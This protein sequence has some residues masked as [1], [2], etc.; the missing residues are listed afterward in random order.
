MGYNFG[1]YLQHWLSLNQPTRHMPKIFHVNWFRLNEQGKFVWPGFGENIRVL[2]WICRRVNGDD[3]AVPSAIGMLPVE[4]SLNLKG[5]D[6]V[7]WEEN[8]SL[9]K[10]YWEEDIEE[11]KQFLQNQ[12]GSDLPT[13]ISEEVSKQEERIRSM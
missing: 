10:N 1:D 13:T 3:I 7:S 4:G 5:L 6:G 11:T 8:F 9:P 12:V 2:D